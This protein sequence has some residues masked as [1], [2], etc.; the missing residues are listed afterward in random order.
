MRF[1][2][3]HTGT[4]DVLTRPENIFRRAS[5]SI[6]TTPPAF[7][8]WATSK[9]DKEIR[10]WPKRLFQQALKSNPDYSEALLELANLRIA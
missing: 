9:D 6:R 3:S 4:W 2:G 10:Q 5:S 7:S 8:T 1:S